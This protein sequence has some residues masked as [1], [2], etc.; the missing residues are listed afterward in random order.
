MMKSV[1]TV[2]LF[3]WIANEAKGGKQVEALTKI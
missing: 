1:G 3:V 2:V